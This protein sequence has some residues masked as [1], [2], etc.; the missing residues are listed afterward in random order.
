MRISLLA[1]LLGCHGGERGTDPPADGWAN[2]APARALE[3]VDLGEHQLV[4]IAESQ[5]TF[6]AQI[7]DVGVKKGDLLLLGRGKER[8][9]VEV[10]ALGRHLSAVV[11]IANVSVVDAETAA[12]AVAG[13]RPAE[14]LPVAEVYARLT[15]LDGSDLVV[16]GVAVKVTDAVGSFWVHVQDGTGAVETG[17]QDLMV[18]S[19]T[20][21]PVGSRSAF[22]GRLQKDAD[23]GFGYHYKALLAEAAP[24]P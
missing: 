13:E 9:D 2:V 21:V 17:D 4:Q 24:I 3:V 6:W 11:D 16:Y 8:Y 14:A 7:P 15:E 19:A 22:K 10:P 12:A 1:L 23:L 18:Q 5:W 20:R